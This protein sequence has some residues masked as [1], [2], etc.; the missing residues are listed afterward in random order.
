MLS[1]I[2]TRLDVGGDDDVGA[3]QPADGYGGHPA[4][5]G[6]GKR[7]TTGISASFPDA[8]GAIAAGAGVEGPV[9]NW[10]KGS[11]TGHPDGLVVA[12]HPSFEVAI[13]RSAV[14]IANEYH[15]LAT[16]LGEAGGS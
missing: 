13:P 11:G 10:E 6:G 12:Y 1:Q 7:S 2:R 8:P 9:V 14:V 16:G 15:P 5:A 3:V 4:S